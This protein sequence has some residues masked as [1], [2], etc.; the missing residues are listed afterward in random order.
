MPIGFKN[1]V[2]GDIS[3][4]VTGAV[5]ASLSHTYMRICENGM[6]AITKTH[7]NPDVHIVLRGGES[8]PNYDPSS[9]SD[10]L[11]RLEHVKLPSRLLIDCSHQNSGKN[12]N[13]QT[14]VFQSVIHQI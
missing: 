1:G 13:R 3:A 10:A 7:G 9:V 12:H 5:A 2:A 6:P 11:T 4:A 8:G 14:T